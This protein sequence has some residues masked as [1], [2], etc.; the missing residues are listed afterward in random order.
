MKTFAGKENMEDC[1]S[2]D[3]FDSSCKANHETKNKNFH[4]KFNYIAFNFELIEKK[5]K[6][7]ILIE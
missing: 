7:K 5:K 4:K 2:K 3:S 6:K 1:Y